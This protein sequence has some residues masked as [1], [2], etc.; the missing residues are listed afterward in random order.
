MNL[1][2]DGKGGEGAREGGRNECLRREGEMKEV[3]ERRERKKD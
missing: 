2:M 3:K 1:E